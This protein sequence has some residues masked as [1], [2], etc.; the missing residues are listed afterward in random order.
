MGL[1]HSPLL[2][3]LHVEVLG[4]VL[5]DVEHFYEVLKILL[6]S[7]RQLVV[8]G[9]QGIQ[10]FYPSC[11]FSYCKNFYNSKFRIEH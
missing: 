8:H 9:K 4:G 10:T 6:V 11:L 1:L 2:K 3:L 7:L 5:V